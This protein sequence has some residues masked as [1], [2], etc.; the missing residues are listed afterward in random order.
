S[1]HWFLSF[2]DT[3]AASKNVGAG[4]HFFFNFNNSPDPNAPSPNTVSSG[5]NEAVAGSFCSGEGEGSGGGSACATCSGSIEPVT[6]TATVFVA[7]P[8]QTFVAVSL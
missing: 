7:D 4:Q 6:W 3:Q 2:R 8:P 1:D 5:I